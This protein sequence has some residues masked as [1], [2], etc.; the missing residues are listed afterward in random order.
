M[1]PAAGDRVLLG[2]LIVLIVGVPTVFLRTTFTTFDISQIT[3]LWVL[4][5]SVGLVGVYRFLVAGVV[6][7]GPLTLTVASAAFLGA[8]LL[9]SVLSDQPW[10]SFTGLTVR[11]AGAISYGLCLVL[12]HV[13]YRLGRRRSLQPLVLAF[14]GSWIMS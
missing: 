11:G 6:E 5:V 8:L 13:V 4:A 10:V 3:L 9:T 12:L 14:V 2:L 1:P 7:L